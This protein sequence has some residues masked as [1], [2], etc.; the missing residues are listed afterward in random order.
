MYKNN[1]EIVVARYNESLTW[2]NEYPFNQ[3]EYIVYN[4]GDN[5]NFVKTNVKE[6]VRL[7]NVGRCDHTYLYHIV[8]NYDKLSNIVVFFPGSVNM[9]NK[10][11]K[12]HKILNNIIA[13]NYEKAFFVGSYHNSIKN[14]LYHFSLDSYKCSYSENANKNRESHLYKCRLRPFGNWYNFFFGDTQAHWVTYGGVFCV[15]RRD[16]I[17][18]PVGRYENLRNIVR[19][20]SNPEAGHYI[21]R[22]WGAIFYPLVYTLKLKE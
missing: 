19:V 1:V 5:D 4:K 17:Q 9:Q 16:I 3:F 15:D 8:A 12:A 11:P 18:H 14:D 2:L 7:P 10:L 6:I 21:E 13:S 22:S 20:H